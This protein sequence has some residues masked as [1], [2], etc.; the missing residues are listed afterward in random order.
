MAGQRLGHIPTYAGERI[1]LRT[2]QGDDLVDALDCFFSLHYISACR[3]CQL[4]L[5]T[6]EV[7][8]AI[9]VSRHD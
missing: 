7:E 2:P 8:A 4:S 3:Y 9:Q 5:T 6:Q 1:D